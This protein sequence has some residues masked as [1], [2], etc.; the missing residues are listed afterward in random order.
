[1]MIIVIRVVKF[2]SGGA[3][4]V[5]FLPKNQHAQRKLLDFVNWTNWEE[6]KI[7]QI[8]YS[9][10]FR[11]SNYHVSS[12]KHQ[13]VDRTHNKGPLV[14]SFGKKLEIDWVWVGFQMTIFYL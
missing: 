7:E 12:Y 13:D 6:S 10:L 3:K 14:N 9:L 4:L 1:M 11:K 5:R 2:S 8:G